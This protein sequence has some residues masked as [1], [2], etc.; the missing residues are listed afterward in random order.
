MELPAKV[1]VIDGKSI[2]SEESFYI[3]LAQLLG[4]PSYFG[5]N[6]DALWDCLVNE[7]KGPVTVVWQDSAWSQKAIGANFSRLH[8]LLVTE[9]P[10]QR[11]D[12]EFILK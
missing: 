6:L 11:R 5:R 7:V 12:I 2:V 10:E 8:Q 4:F 9:L 3:V 1:L